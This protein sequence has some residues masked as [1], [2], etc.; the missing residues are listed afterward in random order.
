MIH[1][2]MRAVKAQA[3]EVQERKEK[4]EKKG[5]EANRMVGAKEAAL[6][7]LRDGAIRYELDEQWLKFD[8]MTPSKHLPD[9][10]S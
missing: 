2:K 7:G 4:V 8:D 3:E 9:G 1:H 5:V 10:V 6:E